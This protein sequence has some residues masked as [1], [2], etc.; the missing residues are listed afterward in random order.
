LETNL[1]S[2]SAD[3]REQNTEEFV[4]QNAKITQKLDPT[5]PVKNS[6]NRAEFEH[7]FEASQQSKFAAKFDPNFSQI[8]EQLTEEGGP[9][10]DKIA[11]IIDPNLGSISQENSSQFETNFNEIAPTDEDEIDDNFDDGDDE[12]EGN[13]EKKRGR[14]HVKASMIAER[15][16]CSL[17]QIRLA[18]ENE[19]LPAN[20]RLVISNRTDKETDPVEEWK[21]KTSSLDGW[22]PPLLPKKR[23]RRPR[24]TKK[25]VEAAIS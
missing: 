3:Q 9:N 18:V 2:I 19:Q 21:I 13:L 15:Y 6:E 7:Q 8:G 12:I 25:L 24:Q 17:E 23:G 16:Q 22:V 20:N 10:T 1:D 11:S 14:Y 5:I 4:L